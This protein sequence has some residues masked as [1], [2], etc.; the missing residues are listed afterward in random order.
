M[1]VFMKLTTCK[2]FGVPPWYPLQSFLSDLWT[3]L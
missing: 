1:N 3:G 2:T